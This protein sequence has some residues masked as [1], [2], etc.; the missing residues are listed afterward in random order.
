MAGL[1]KRGDTWHLRMRLPERYRKA[2]GTT[3]VEVHRSLKTDS[4]RRARE[5]LPAVE[6]SILEDLDARISVK[7][8]SSDKVRAFRDATKVANGRGFAYRPAADIADGDL[9]EALERFEAIGPNDGSEVARAVLGG[10][11]KPDLR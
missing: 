3:Q 1:V 4:E 2:L 10:V 7:A 11:E 8:G 6:A 9:D 5:L